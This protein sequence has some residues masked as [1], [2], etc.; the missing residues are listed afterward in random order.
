MRLEVSSWP[1]AQSETNSDF[2]L[3]GNQILNRHV[4]IKKALEKEREDLLFERWTRRL[5]WLPS[6]LRVIN[7]GWVLGH[8]KYSCLLLV[9]T[10]HA[11]G[12]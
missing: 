11:S 6:G 2:V 5:W 7:I 4:R 9:A 8:F 10:N 12:M 3:L 1:P